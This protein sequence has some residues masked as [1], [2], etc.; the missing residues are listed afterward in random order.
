MTRDNI[1]AMLPPDKN[2][3]ECFEGQ[4]L[5]EIGRNIGADYAVQGTV[6]RYGQNLTLSIEAYETISGLLIGSF[7]SE[8]QNV[9][10][11]LSAMREKAPALFSK[12]RP[13]PVA[14]A[15]DSIPAPQSISTQIP[16]EGKGTSLSWLPWTLD[17]L[18]VA[19]LVFGFYQ[20]SE[21]DSKLKAYRNLP[22]NSSQSEFDKKWKAF[23]SAKTMRTVGYAVGGVFLAGGIALHFVF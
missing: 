6:S 7:T 14:T 12:I 23:E 1:L 5:V 21:A 19:G 4:C 17:A 22:D 10:G 8:S 16:Q 20:N 11:L 3:A 15:L 2:A 18:G 9:D 13:A